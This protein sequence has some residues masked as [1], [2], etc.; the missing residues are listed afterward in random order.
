MSPLGNPVRSRHG[1]REG[2]KPVKGEEG[3]LEKEVLTPKDQWPEDPKPG[4]EGEEASR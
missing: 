1:S 4:D 2:K 3:L